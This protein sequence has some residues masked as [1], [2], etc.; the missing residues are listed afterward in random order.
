MKA[1]PNCSELLGDTVDKCFKCNYNLKMRKVITNAEELKRE[2]VFLEQKIREQIT[3]NPLY[4]Y[5]VVVVGDLETGE[6]DKET[7][8]AKLEKYSSIGWRLHSIQ[9]NEIGKV[10]KSVSISYL[11]SSVNPVMGQTILIFERCIVS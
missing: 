5:R 4:E 7:I 1:C 6:V 10:S 8:Q 2:E 11:G 3:S 9:K